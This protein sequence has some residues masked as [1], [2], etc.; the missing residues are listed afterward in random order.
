MIDCTRAH[1]QGAAIGMYGVLQM[2]RLHQT[3]PGVGGES[4]T[5]P[6]NGIAA[7]LPGSLLRWLE[8][9]IAHGG[10]RKFGSNQAVGL[11]QRK[12]DESSA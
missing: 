7:N 1:G 10:V 9:E 4:T 5:S 2:D 3:K 6:G 8:A 11:T 12:V